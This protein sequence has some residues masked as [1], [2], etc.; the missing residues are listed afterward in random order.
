MT[1]Q[2][3]IHTLDKFVENQINLEQASQE[4][5]GKSNG[6]VHGVH[7]ML[8][9]LANTIEGVI[10]PQQAV[11]QLKHAYKATTQEAEQLMIILSK[12]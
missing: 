5:I 9:I 1:I 7:S 12:L 11:L 8:T 3:I 6:D 10:T 2:N 4:F